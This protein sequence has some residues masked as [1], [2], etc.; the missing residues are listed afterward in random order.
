MLEIVEGFHE[1]LGNFRGKKVADRMEEPLPFIGRKGFD[2]V[3]ELFGGH[4]HEIKNHDQWA[5]A[6]TERLFS[7]RFTF[8]S[9]TIQFEMPAQPVAGRIHHQLIRLRARNRR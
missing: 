6:I 2:F 9:D 3:E 1:V 7:S 8:T 5:C 4:A